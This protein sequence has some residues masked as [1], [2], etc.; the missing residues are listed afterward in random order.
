MTKKRSKRA[1]FSDEV[2]NAIEDSGLSRYRIAKDA[3]IDQSTL[4]RFVHGQRTLSLETVDR[5][6]ELLGW[7]LDVG[8]KKSK[9][10]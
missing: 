4:S 5:L 2:R 3:D 10:K 7:H 8:S 9:G 1:A 6:A